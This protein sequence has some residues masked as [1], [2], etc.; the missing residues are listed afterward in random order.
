MQSQGTLNSQNNLEK[1]YKVGVF[2]LF[3]FKTYYKA[4]LIN[5]VWNQHKDRLID[6][7]NRT[8][9]SEINSYLQSTDF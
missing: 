4:T 5:T 9:S 8:G 7:Q 1:K 6:Q 2:I 3:D